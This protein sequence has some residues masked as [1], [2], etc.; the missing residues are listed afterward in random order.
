MQNMSACV[1]WTEGWLDRRQLLIYQL[2]WWGPQGRGY[3]PASK[4]I[5]PGKCTELNLSAKED[6][7]EE[8]FNSG[9]R[10]LLQKHEEN[11]SKL[12]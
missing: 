6:F 5:N 3:V 9:N 10:F 11:C 4:L 8:S 12:L 7:T 1:K 2:K